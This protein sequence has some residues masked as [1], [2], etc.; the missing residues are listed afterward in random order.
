MSKEIKYN[1]LI[2]GVG[3]TIRGDDG[4][5]PYICSCI[6]ALQLGGI[7]TRITQQ[8]QTDMVDELL[9]YHQIIIADAAIHSE[10]I[11]FYAVDSTTSPAASSHHS[12]PAML[13]ALAQQLYNKKL[14]IMVC[15]VKGEVF[16]MSDQLSPAAKERADKA[17]VMI[18]EWIKES[19]V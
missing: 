14:P 7:K 6:E 8:L 1:T 10:D 13:V 16:E 17:V 15:S 9:E 4:I 12:N 3:N 19:S 18:S 2:I 5:G 11:L